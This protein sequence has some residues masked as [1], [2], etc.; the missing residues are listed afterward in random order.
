MFQ[1]L[2]KWAIVN[3]V[4]TILKQRHRE[5]VLPCSILFWKW[6]WNNH[7]N[8]YLIFNLKMK[9]SIIYYHCKDID[10]SVFVTITNQVR[11]FFVSILFKQF[12]SL[13]P[14][15]SSMIPIVLCKYRLGCFEVSY[16]KSICNLYC[17]LTINRSH[18]Y[19]TKFCYLLKISTQSWKPFLWASMS[20]VSPSWVLG[21]A[22]AFKP[23]NNWTTSDRPLQ[24]A[25]CSGTHPVFAFLL[26]TWAWPFCISSLMVVKWLLWHAYW[27]WKILFHCCNLGRLH[28]TQFTYMKWCVSCSI[29]TINISTC[30]N[31]FQ[32]YIICSF[33]ACQMSSSLSVFTLG[34]SVSVSTF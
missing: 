8:E 15:Q 7:L 11:S 18:F 17:P 29:S 4:I 31:Q 24:A 16:M 6:L 34:I 3:E 10:P 5:N 26:W 13:F 19:F 22:G 14:V 33:A 12:H 23:S 20:G 28:S 1:A 2:K 9:T 21:C 27:K 32:E 25:S 30:F